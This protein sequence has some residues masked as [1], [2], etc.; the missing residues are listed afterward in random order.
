MPVLVCQEGW[1]TQSVYTH[2]API[3]PV[4]VST[5]IWQGSRSLQLCPLRLVQ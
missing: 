3:A 2:T 4:K 5:C 1:H